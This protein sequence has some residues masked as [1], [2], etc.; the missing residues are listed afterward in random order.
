LRVAS[1]TGYFA[2]LVL[3]TRNDWPE[4]N[5]ILQQAVGSISPDGHQP[6][7]DNWIRLGAPESLDARSL[8]IDLLILIVVIAI[9]VGVNIFWNCSLSKMVQRQNTS[10]C[11]SEERYRRIVDLSQEAALVYVDDKLVFANQAILRQVNASSSDDVLGK[12][13]GDFVHPDHRE[14]SQERRIRM[15][16]NGRPIPLTELKRLRL[17]GTEY[18]G[19]VAVLL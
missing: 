16:P 12:S 2:R 10:S 6:I 7:L 15:L 5:T 14:D 17:D 1:K 3:A 8:L 13:S 4:L 18:D 11:E 19:E 9:A